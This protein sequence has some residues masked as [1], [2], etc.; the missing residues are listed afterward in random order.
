V[1]HWD[2]IV[3][4]GGASGLVAAGSAARNAAHVLVCEKMPRIARKVGIAGKG[5]CNVTNDKPVDLFVDGYRNGG[6]FLRS[7][8]SRFFVRDTIELLERRQVPCLVERGGRVFPASGKAG[9]VVNALYRYARASGGAVRTDAAITAISRATDGFEVTTAGGG[10]L[11]RRLILATGG[12]SYPAT[13]STGDGYRFA[14]ALGHQVVTPRPALAPLIIAGSSPDLRVH[15]RNAT[16]TLLDGKQ[17]VGEGF[18]EA[19]LLG[20]KLEG[21]VPLQFARDVSGLKEPRVSIDLKPALDAEK[22]DARLRRDLEHDGKVHLQKVIDGL[23][24]QALIPLFVER[25]HLDLEQR[26]AEVSRK[27]R[28]ALVA[29]CKNLLFA[30]TGVGGWELALVTAG[31]VALDEVDPRTMESKIVPGLFLCG[32]VLD[33]DGQS[34]GYNLQ[35]A[36]STGFVAGLGASEAKP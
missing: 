36:F 2:I 29:L 23:L 27:G 28:Q 21:P 34:G 22:L 6:D 25:L 32:E 11:C 12:K 10:L 16:I 13:G 3:V 17:K 14:R 9:D 33:I 5:R 8:F 31:G 18:G 26:C 1:E 35:A 4:G 20:D 15:L 30:V 24:P 19:S 7:A